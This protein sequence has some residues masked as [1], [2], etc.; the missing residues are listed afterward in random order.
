M[1]SVSFVGDH[2]TQ[3]FQNWPGLASQPV[4]SQTTQTTILAGV[5]QADFDALKKEVLEM[6]ELLKKAKLYDEQTGQKDC[7]MEEKVALLR[8]VAEAVGINLDDVLPVL[9]TQQD[10]KA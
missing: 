5:S 9:Q 4:P 10:D 2:Y 7:V 6:K 3:K 8:K 1:C